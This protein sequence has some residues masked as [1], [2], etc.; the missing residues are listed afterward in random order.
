MIRIKYLH[1]HVYRTP[2]S[3]IER[4][5][6]LFI[7]DPDCKEY[8][9][10]L[11]YDEMPIGTSPGTYEIEELA[12]PREHTIL[13]TQ[14]PPSIKIYPKCYT[15]QFAHVFTTL[16]PKYLPHPNHHFG[17][18]TMHWYADYPEEEVFSMPDYEKTADL[19]TVCSA[20]QQTHTLHQK[21]YQLISALKK[22][23]PEMDWYGRGVLPLQKKYEALS[24]YRYHIAVENYIEDYHWSDKISDPILG[25]CLAFYAGDPRLGEVLPPE[26]FIPIPLEDHAEAARIIK[27]AIRN[28][29]YEKRLPAI[30]EARR[31]IVEKYNFYNRVAALIHQ[32]Q[33]QEKECTPAV[34]PGVKIRGRHR[35]R[36]NPLNALCEAWEIWKAKR[37]LARDKRRK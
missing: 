9:W 34:E 12:C 33:E 27:E 29:E 8:D 3:T 16:L 22:E 2:K 17:E 24:P 7:A 37:E 21:R 4:D 5:G 31:R 28:N 35:L 36:R 18:G 30:R 32:I 19:S 14:E 6:C 26:S 23:I 1:K 25:L 15:R 20:K 13:V 11:V 10:L